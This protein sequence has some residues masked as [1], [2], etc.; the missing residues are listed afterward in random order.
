MARRSRKHFSQAVSD[1]HDRRLPEPARPAGYA[2]LIDAYDL[3]VP[4]PR[5]LSAI[6][7]KH[8]TILKDGWRILTPRHEP[9]ATL[10]GHLTFAVKHEGLDLAV[11]KR[12]F[13]AVGPNE[14]ATLVRAA[15]TGGYARRIWFLYEFAKLTEAEVR[16]VEGAYAET[17][18]APA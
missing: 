16:Q 11:L 5:T 7:T 8:R 1:F 3:K 2:A 18:E 15:P 13:L 14:I 17:I 6:G 9:E 12:L 4:L 10:E